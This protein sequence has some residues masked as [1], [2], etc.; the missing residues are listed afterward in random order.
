MLRKFQMQRGDAVLRTRRPIGPR[1]RRV[2]A[3]RNVIERRGAALSESEF[4]LYGVVVGG[5]GDW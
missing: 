2:E 4:G 5:D 1:R 3:G